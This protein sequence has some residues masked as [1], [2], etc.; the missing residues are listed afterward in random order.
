MKAPWTDP[1]LRELVALAALAAFGCGL[2]LA[3]G[4]LLFLAVF[5]AASVVTII[6][7]YDVRAEV[8]G[9][10]GGSGRLIRFSPRT[11][12]RAISPMHLHLSGRDCARRLWQVR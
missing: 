2:A 5:A 1:T 8:I 7:G 10:A 11:N 12:G 9:P 4:D 3:L 6:G